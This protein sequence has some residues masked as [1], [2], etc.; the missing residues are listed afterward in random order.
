MWLMADIGSGFSLCNDD[1]VAAV[2]KVRGS[3]MNLVTLTGG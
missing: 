1:I 2:V 3:E